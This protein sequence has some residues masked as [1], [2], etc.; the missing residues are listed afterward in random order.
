VRELRPFALLQA[1]STWPPMVLPTRTPAADAR[2]ALARLTPRSIFSYWR[3]TWRRLTAVF[4]PPLLVLIVGFVAYRG[5][6]RIVSARLDIVHSRA[7]THAADQVVAWLKDGETGQRGYLLT[8]DEEYLAP[9][10]RAAD[11][12]GPTIEQLRK[13]VIAAGAGAD[14]RLAVD[15]LAILSRAKFAE[16][17]EAIRLRR[18][19]GAGAARALMQTGRGRDLMRDA[20]RIATSIRAQEEH[21]FATREASEAQ[22]AREVTFIVVLGTGAAFLIALL[23]NVLLAREAAIQTRLAA[24]RDEVLEELGAQSTELQH[25][26]SEL[27]AANEELVSSNEELQATTEEL[28]EKTAMVEEAR[29][30]ASEILESIGDAFFA[31]DFDWRFIYLNDK[32]EPLLERTRE[33]LIGANLWEAFPEAVGTTIEREYRRAMD[34]QVSVGFEEYFAPLDR[35][36][37]IRAY[38]SRRGLAVYLTDVTARVRAERSFRALAETMPQMVWS[39][40]ASGENEY[41]N[42]RWL[43]YTGMPKVASERRDWRDAVHPGDAEQVGERL[44][45]SFASGDPFEVDCRLRRGSDGAYRWFL[46]RALPLRDDEGN[47]TRWFGTCTDVHDQR[48]A[49]DGLSVLADASAVLAASLDTDDSLAE[50]ARL[51]VPRLGDWCTVDLLA[52]NGTLRRLATVHIDPN[53]LA[54]AD[55]LHRRYPVTPDSAGGVMNVLR[56]GQTQAGE[57]TDELLTAGVPD[58]G[59]RNLL[60]AL[61]LRSYVIAPLRVGGKVVGALTIVSAESGHFFGAG[62]ITRIEELARRMALALE[63]AQLFGETIA[64][65]DAAAV[66]NAL[67][68]ESEAKLVLSMEAGGLGAWEW[69]V[70]SGRIFWSP[71]TERMHGLAEGTFSGTLDEFRSYVYPDDRAR[72]EEEI[73]RTLSDRVPSYHIKYRFVRADGAVR[74]L[75]GFGRLQ[76]D[77]RGEPASLFGVSH[78]VTEREALLEGEQQARLEA[79]A[80]NAAKAI[81]LTT[82]SHE[83]RTPLNAVSGYVD[84]L[85]MGV[86][87]PITELQRVDLRRIR[88]ASQHLLVLINDILNYAR[89]EAGTVELHPSEVRLTDA[90]TEMEALITPQLTAKGVEY[91]YR[92]CDAKFRVLADREKLDQ[93]LLNL[94]GNA[95]KFTD[96]GGKITLDCGVADG[97]AHVTITDTG[98]GIPRGKLDMIFD[99]FVQVDRHLTPER[100]QGVGLGLAISRDLARAMHGDITVESDAGKGAI[101][102]LT[103]PVISAPDGAFA[104]S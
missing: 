62:D 99:P 36:F 69:D 34:D 17:A 44:R 91:E 63:H 104:E 65:R 81:F 96:R 7:V 57:I 88:R 39:A 78:D 30:Q 4:G 84:L 52:P 58:V 73:R 48:R 28:E 56:T 90:L 38:P 50:V 21:R 76:T 103:L 29:Q 102:T 101:F 49:N 71:Q 87:G 15:S 31:V 86:R 98:R 33:E 51:A 14:T 77:E 45:H 25:K 43:S 42:E 5:T 85:E 32:V 72:V 79:E 46:C 82:M 37:H 6:T 16:L 95:V 26:A 41:F 3:I 83:L 47:I 9:Y 74:W 23:V 27:E 66:S 12:L 10:H 20:R 92:G 89:L 70:K 53:R 11:S 68:R 55:E 22:Y 100:Q 97:I 18:V 61:E 1:A 75:E 64:A 40:T 80:A 35:W 94:V 13:A 67:L 54:I 19:A 93:I 59:R 2:A 24:E 8:N 60:L